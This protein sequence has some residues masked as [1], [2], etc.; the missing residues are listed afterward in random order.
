MSMLA[1]HS[2]LSD[3]QALG[4]GYNRKLHDDF[5][6]LKA[7]LG[8]SYPEIALEINVLADTLQLY[9]N[10]PSIGNFKE[11]EKKLAR[12]VG[13]KI[14]PGL[15]QDS[16]YLAISP[17]EKGLTICQ[18]SRIERIM[19]L[20]IASSGWGKATFENEFCRRFPDTVFISCDVTIR[21]LGAVLD[22]LGH[23]M[24]VA[25]NHLNNTAFLLKIIDNLKNSGRLLIVDECHFLSW[26]GFEIFRKIH[27]WAK[28]G[29][30]Y[31]GQEYTLSQMRGRKGF[32][33]DQIFSRLSIT[34]ELNTL[35]R[36][37]VV[38]LADSVCSGLDKR[39]IDFLANKARG[40][41]HF[42]VMMTVLRR[43]AQLAQAENIPLTL[44]ILKEANEF[45]GGLL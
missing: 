34:C 23:Q 26:P 8:I 33:Y 31:S 18:A 45:S 16:N 43:A 4:D 9:A 36:N 35:E 41:G 7:Q 5:L 40:R 19:A 11:L 22:L 32:L 14:N 28:V 38:L 13:K 42:R 29:V 37:D 2:N 27:D 1:L 20:I 44:N 10:K 24:P 30:V 15:L 17:S 3:D 6:F 25:R 21:S 39:C 12:W